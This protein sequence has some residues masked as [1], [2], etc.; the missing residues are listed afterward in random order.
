MLLIDGNGEVVAARPKLYQSERVKLL[1]LNDN[2]QEADACTECGYLLTQEKEKGE[3]YFYKKCRACR[4][5]KEF[6]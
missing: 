6:F 4:P 3:S 2:S 1:K 5:K